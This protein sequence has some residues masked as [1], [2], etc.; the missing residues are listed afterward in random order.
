M[1][2][3]K[4]LSHYFKILAD[5]DFKRRISLLWLDISPL[6]SQDVTKVNINMIYFFGPKSVY[7]KFPLDG[8]SDKFKNIMKHIESNGLISLS[9]KSLINAS[10]EKEFYDI[11]NPYLFNGVNF[12]TLHFDISCLDKI[13]NIKG[14]S[15]Q[16]PNFRNISIENENDTCY[17]ICINSEVSKVIS[18]TK[19]N[20]EILKLLVK[21]LSENIKDKRWGSINL[22]VNN[23]SNF[24]FSELV[25]YVSD[26][27]S[28]IK[29]IVYKIQ[30]SED[31]F[32]CQHE[33]KEFRGSSS[34]WKSERSNLGCYYLWIVNKGYLENQEDQITDIYFFVNLLS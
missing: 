17:K 3:I 21:I 29:E 2:N 16:T 26:N 8:N 18:E 28:I 20:F 25:S 14:F 6:A 30:T 1:N 7:A 22:V 5:N 15:F 4:V 27:E 11:V 32:Q 13:Q 34:E 33:I 23:N 10:D 12:E 24:F 19:S 9:I 31:E